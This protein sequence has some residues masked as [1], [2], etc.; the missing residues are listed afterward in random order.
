[1]GEVIM[2]DFN[3]GRREVNTSRWLYGT[4]L[5]CQ[6]T[7]ERAMVLCDL[8]EHKLIILEVQQKNQ[9]GGHTVVARCIRRELLVHWHKASPPEILNTFSRGTRVVLAT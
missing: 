8:P 6:E 5:W 1:M 2:V 7:Q 9:R 4:H 3:L